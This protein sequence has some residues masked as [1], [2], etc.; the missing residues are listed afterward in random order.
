MNS[1]YVTKKLDLTYIAYTLCI[2]Y[3]REYTYNIVIIHAEMEDLDSI[4][5][6]KVNCGEELMRFA[7]VSSIYIS[8][9]RYCMQCIRTPQLS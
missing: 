3:D 8:T 4:Y 7:A 2:I 5:I 6:Y 9:I 1:Y